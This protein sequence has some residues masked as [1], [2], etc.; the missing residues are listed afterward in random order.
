MILGAGDIYAFLDK[1]LESDIENDPCLLKVDDF[2]DQL[3]E[4]K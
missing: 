3:S 4:P 1:W 2:F